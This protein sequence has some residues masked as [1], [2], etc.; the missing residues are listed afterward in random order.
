MLRQTFIRTALAAAGAV[1]VM[2]TASLPAS[3][4]DAQL[5]TN[6]EI[7]IRGVIAAVNPATR[8]I[9]V[10]SNERE[11]L[12]YR[13]SDRVTNFKGL[14]VDQVVD[15]R[16]YRAMDFLLAKTTPAVTAQAKALTSKPARA[17][18]LEGT[19]MPIALW[20][21]SG[22]VVKA[23]PSSNKIDVV[24]PSPAG[25]LV[26]RTPWFKKPENQATLKS[27]QPGDNI[28]AVFSERTALEVTV[29]R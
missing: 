15:V 10:Y 22:M 28:T 17:P 8:T 5:T 20:Q 25:G 18:G 4:A 9:V 11:Y 16:Y 29:V 6:D 1:A 26:Y 14:K 13:A 27:L 21:V 2:A 23:D 19:K 3:A 7:T 12:N 24:D